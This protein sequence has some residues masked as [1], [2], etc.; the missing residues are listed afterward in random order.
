MDEDTILATLVSRYENGRIYTYIGDVLVALNPFN[1]LPIYGKS[2]SARYH[3]S[4][5]FH[6]DLPPHVYGTCENALRARGVTG[7]SQCLVVGGESGSGK[8]EAAKHLM[9][10]ILWSA[11]SRET[12]LAAKMAQ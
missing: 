2:T 7:S 3:N 5:E 6:T 1:K 12:G 9:Q 8:T 10:H 11:G 4:A